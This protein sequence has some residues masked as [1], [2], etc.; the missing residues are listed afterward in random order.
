MITSIQPPT[1]EIRVQLPTDKVAAIA[2]AA[3]AAG[4]TIEEHID[5]VLTAELAKTKTAA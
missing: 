4:Q 5:F 1:E 2:A 3:A